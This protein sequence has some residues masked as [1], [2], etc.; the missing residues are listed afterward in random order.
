[1]FSSPEGLVDN[2]HFNLHFNTASS[3]RLLASE[4]HD[5]LSYSLNVT[6]LIPEIDLDSLLITGELSTQWS[7]ASLVI[8]VFY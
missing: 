4:V 8:M 3:G 2:V 5:V 1:M 7:V 6:N